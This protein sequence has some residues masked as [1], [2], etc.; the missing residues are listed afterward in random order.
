MRR[1]PTLVSFVARSF[2]SPRYDVYLDKLRALLH[3]LVAYGPA[4]ECPLIA[5]VRS[6]IARRTPLRL[7]TE[8]G[9]VV[10]AGV[11]EMFLRLAEFD[12]FAA[13]KE[14]VLQLVGDNPVNQWCHEDAERIDL[15]F[16]GDM[17][18]IVKQGQQELRQTYKKK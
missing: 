17:H 14:A 9:L 12:S 7:G 6:A 16:I 18:A 3:E 1:P 11:A 4:K 13:E 2:S 15:H 8:E 5:R 10:Q